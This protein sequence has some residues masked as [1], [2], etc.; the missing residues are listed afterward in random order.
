MNLSNDLA[1]DLTDKPGKRER[2]RPSLP[3]FRG[4]FIEN[5]SIDCHY[6][7]NKSYTGM[8][9]HF[10]W[11]LDGNISIKPQVTYVLYAQEVVTHYI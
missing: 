11:Y 3:S 9:Y 1:I 6:L 2:D 8:V 10:P 4:F 5:L 7:G